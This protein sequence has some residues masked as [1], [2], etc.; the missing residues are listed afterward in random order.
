[1]LCRVCVVRLGM[2]RTD[3]FDK[4][5]PLLRELAN[6]GMHDRS[7]KRLFFRSRLLGAVLLDFVECAGFN[8]VQRNNL[9]FLTPAAAAETVSRHLLRFAVLV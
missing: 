2:C 4:K 8:K 1:M 3:S 6:V 7:L 9:P 5:L